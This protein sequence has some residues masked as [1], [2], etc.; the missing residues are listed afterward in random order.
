MKVLREQWQCVYYKIVLFKNYLKSY[1]K[2]IK[3]HK[4]DIVF[5]FHWFENFFPGILKKGVRKN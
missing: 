2:K 4:S 3:Y 5:Y 1:L